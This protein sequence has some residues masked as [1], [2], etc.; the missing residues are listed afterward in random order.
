MFYET[1]EDTH[2]LAVY[3][4]GFSFHINT[5]THHIDVSAFGS[6]LFC[7]GPVLG[8]WKV[9]HCGMHTPY[10]LK[11]KTNLNARRAPAPAKYRTQ[12]FDCSGHRI[13]MFCVC[14]VYAFNVKRQIEMPRTTGQRARQTREK[15][16]KTNFRMLFKSLRFILRLFHLDQHFWCAMPCYVVW[17]WSRCDS[18]PNQISHRSILE[19]NTYNILY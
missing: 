9:W 5:H 3:D 8:M 2:K 6:I 7:I 1:P 18:L 16:E 14:T 11:W 17:W 13:C 4:F 19:K 12:C 15:R 10:T